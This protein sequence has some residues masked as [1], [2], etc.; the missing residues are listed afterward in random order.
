MRALS[1]N[2]RT[3]I[4]SDHDERD[5]SVPP[6]LVATEAELALLGGLMVEPTFLTNIRDAIAPDDFANTACQRVFK[7]M[8]ALADS[9]A[10]IDKVS[11]AEHLRENSHLEE[12]G[13][14]EFLGLLL[15]AVPTAATLGYYAQHVRAASDRRILTSS[16]R[17]VLLRVHRDEDFTGIADDLRGLSAALR[18]GGGV[19]DGDN[20]RLHSVRATEVR[21]LK[22]AWFMHGRMPFGEFQLLEGEGGI[23]KT[24]AA[25]DLI[26]AATGSLSLPDG[27]RL[28]SPLNA[29]V[30]AEEDCQAMLKARLVAAGADLSRVLFADYIEQSDG[31]HQTP[32]SLPTHLLQLER[33]VRESKARLFYIDALFSHFDPNLDAHRAQ[34]VRRVCRPLA[35]LAHETGVAVWATRHWTKA[36]G[37]AASRGLG[38]ADLRNSARAVV[39]FGKHPTRYDSEGICVAT[40]S[41]SNYGPPME[42][43]LYRIEPVPFKADDGSNF[44]GGIG[45]VR[46][47][48]TDRTTADD[49]AGILPPI[50]ERNQ[51]SEAREVIT[52]L[53]ASGEKTALQ[54]EDE[55][56]LSSIA[57]RTWQRARRD[58]R[59]DGVITRHGGGTA[60]PVRW[61]LNATQRHD[62]PN[63]ASSVDWR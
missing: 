39:T 24:T 41:K 60:G 9:G 56:K 1:F 58:L 15:N 35:N 40:V 63:I 28:A 61:S 5:G 55:R 2:G 13:G 52:D 23:G 3:R 34:D 36:A 53:L 17:S 54:M 26:A 44:E 32:F 49:I 31:G 45:R 51:R 46:W 10:P 22:P 38:S 11:V 21:I 12:V 30:L 50:D 6:R 43:L 27:T 8:L 20:C 33:L 48:G 19:G 18:S 16:L 57:E 47:L 14:P 62:P 4:G 7:T 29:I 25:L 37:S 42:A 59:K